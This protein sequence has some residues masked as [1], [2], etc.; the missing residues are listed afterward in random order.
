MPWWAPLAIIGGAVV[1]VAVA[2]AL[3]LGTPKQASD[4]HS[5]GDGRLGYEETDT[6][7]YAR[8]NPAAFVVIGGIIALII[9]LA[10]GLS[11]G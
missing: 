4:G 8:W 5:H 7:N 11:A 6:T 3:V 1:G 2:A 10:I 9:G